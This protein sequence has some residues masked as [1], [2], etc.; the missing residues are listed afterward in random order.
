MY[1]A[2][3]RKCPEIQAVV[4]T[5]PRYTNE[6]FELNQNGFEKYP[7]GRFKDAVFFYN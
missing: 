4:H 5:H 6:L 1:P 2:C 3:Y 7:R